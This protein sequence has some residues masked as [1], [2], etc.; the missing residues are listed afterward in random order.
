[1][2]VMHCEYRRRSGLGEVTAVPYKVLI[3]DDEEPIVELIEYNLRRA[4]LQTV[5]A[6]DGDTAVRLTQAQQPDL[7][8]LDLMLP[9]IDGFEV[10]RRI[11]RFS[12]VPIL[13]LT[14]RDEDTS[15]IVGLEIGADD[16]L[17]KPFNPDVLAARVRAALRRAGTQPAPAPAEPQPAATGAAVV[18]VGDLRVDA[19]RHEVTVAG[20]P[21]Q[22]TPREF[23]VLHYLARN[24]GLV[25]SRQML[26][27]RIWGGDYYGDP[28]TVDV[29][30]KHVRDKLGRATNGEP[31][32]VTVRGVGYKV[33]S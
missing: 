28:R 19:A 31:Y 8:L 20:R 29:H 3:V 9:D 12:D 10:C 25:M 6:H 24:A 15:R 30:I 11:R 1:M 7:V 4:G 33:Q 27:D 14:A 16:Y 21:V 2:I 23:D 18:Q 5:S 17:T 26:L 13:F 22:L 32:V